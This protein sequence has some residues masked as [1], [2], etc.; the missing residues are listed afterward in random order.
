MKEKMHAL[1]QSAYYGALNGTLA[2]T[3][4][5]GVVLV[6]CLVSVVSTNVG[7]PINWYALVIEAIA[8]FAIIVYL[9]NSQNL[10]RAPFVESI[11]FYS[12]WILTWVLAAALVF[13]AI[14]MVAATLTTIAMAQSWLTRDALIISAITGGIGVVWCLF[15]YFCPEPSM[16]P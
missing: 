8:L 9:V 5:G 3:L 2:A 1:K 11:Q 14:I 10:E 15:M 7:Q 13:C 4:L 12:V 16:R 6:I